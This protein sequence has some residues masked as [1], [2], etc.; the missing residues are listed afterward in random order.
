MWA[1]LCEYG[2]PRRRTTPGD[3][4]MIVGLWRPQGEPGETRWRVIRRFSATSRGQAIVTTGLASAAGQAVAILV[5]IA[6]IP[7]VLGAIGPRQYG[8]YAALM[9][10]PALATAADFGLGSGTV[11]LLARTTATGDDADA[12]RVASSALVGLLLLSG[13]VLIVG[14]AVAPVVA[15]PLAKTANGD[16]STADVRLAIDML[17]A[18]I[19]VGVPVALGAKVALG[20]QRGWVAGTSVGATAVV[21][22]LG[23]L[24]TRGIGASLPGFVASVSFASAL[25]G[26]VT[27]FAVFKWVLPRWRPSW[28]A[29]NRRQLVAVIRS[30]G[31]FFAL[32]VA[33]AV[34]YET[35]ILLVV[36]ILGADDGTIYAVALRLFAVG[37][38]V[39][40][41]FLTALW[42]AFA[43]ALTAGDAAWVARTFRRAV[44]ITATVNI[45]WAALCVGLAEPVIR[46]WTHQAIRGVPWSLLVALA[47]WTLLNSV[48]G[49]LAM[50]L[51]G[52]HV[53]RPQVLGACAMMLANI[54]I[55][56]ALTY[57]IGLSGPAWGSVISQSAVMLPIAAWAA[58]RVLV[59]ASAGTSPRPN[60]AGVGGCG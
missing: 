4:S 44:L 26:A 46:L 28:A 35:D 16:V 33:A 18:G 7:I 30:G 13:F 29:V 52:A 60:A 17:V 32:A 21:T 11:T 9:T 6:T 5:S 50:L 10:I 48:S 57:K 42:P 40:S 31:L 59:S 55:S 36:S 23:V 37:P 45:L 22:L 3:A 49:P 24:I 19:A 14:L 8:V 1:R 41:F 47:T 25:G 20:A 51:N 15:Q 34:A 53:V 12:R 27:T 43:E 38:L 58:R 39:A 54:G 2:V 56:I